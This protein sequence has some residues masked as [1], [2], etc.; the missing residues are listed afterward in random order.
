MK[1]IAW[2]WKLPKAA[3]E[4]IIRHSRCLVVALISDTCTVA[5]AISSWQSLRFLVGDST[6]L[7]QQGKCPHIALERGTRALLQ[8]QLEKKRIDQFELP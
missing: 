6:E 5:M 7:G 4:S 3:P 8:K 2:Y 1:P